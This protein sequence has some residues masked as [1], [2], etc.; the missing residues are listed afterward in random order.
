MAAERLPPPKS[1]SPLNVEVWSY[2][3]VDSAY[4]DASYIV[5]GIFNGFSLGV[6]DG[7]TSSAK[8]NCPSAYSMP[9]TI[10]LSLNDVNRGAASNASWY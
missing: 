1:I 3:L 7:D 2:Y 5:D 4:E 10:D 9:E 6:I 8:R